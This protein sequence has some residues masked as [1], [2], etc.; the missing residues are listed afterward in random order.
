MALNG[1]SLQVEHCR[2]LVL[3]GPSGGGKSTLL[4]VLAGLETPDAGTV[5]INGTPLVFE[6]Q[7]LLAHRRRIG[8]VFQA[9]NLFP[10]LSALENILLPLT[11]VH[12]NSRDEAVAIAEEL[13]SRFEL[14][15]HA[16][17]KPSALSGGQKQRIAIARALAVK[18]QMLIL[19]EPTSALDPGMTAE[20]LETIAMLKNQGRDFVLATHEMGFA[21]QVADQIAFIADGR[22]MDTGAPEQLFGDRAGLETRRFLEKAL[23]W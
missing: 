12:G 9:F 3:I 4:R 1:F 2:A 7:C 15:G 18:P 21:R 6:E 14:R 23:R 22:L 20:V 17:H 16:D 5:E 19:D 13:L 11:A 10:H 8:V